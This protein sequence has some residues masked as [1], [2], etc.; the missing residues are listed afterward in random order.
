MADGDTKDN[1]FFHAFLQTLAK[2]WKNNFKDN[3][4]FS[5]FG[6]P[7]REIVDGQ[8]NLFEIEN[9]LDEF[10]SFFYLLDDFRS[11]KLLLHLLAFRV[12]GH[13]KIRLPLSATDYSKK[14][15]ELSSL[16]DPEDK[17]EVNYVSSMKKNLFFADLSPL[18]LPVKLY[19]APGTIFS[20]FLLKPYEYITD[21]QIII[22]AKNGNIVIDCG[23]CWGDTTLFFANKVKGN[24]KVYSFE[25]IPN[26]LQ[27]AYKNINL[28]PHFKNIIKIVENPLWDKSGIRMFYRDNGPGSK[29]SLTPFEGHENN[30]YTI[31][32]D[33]FVDQEQLAKIDLIKMD[34]EGAEQNALRGA[35]Q[36][37]RR[38][39][40]ELAISIYHNMNDFANIVHLINNLNLGYKFYL[41]HFTKHYEETVL[42]AKAQ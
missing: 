14:I 18:D 29:V 11:K 42:Y 24:G 5:R 3:F 30:I 21:D 39:K 15:D 1:F 34:I 19:T 2:A 9:F 23:A 17:V 6:E 40:P 13:R 32:I 12:L 7:E 16:I 22:G 26:N 25:F 36:T 27:V 41:D 28:N 35:E 4:S 31:T 10:E 8:E 33:D 20:Q 37:L 38:F